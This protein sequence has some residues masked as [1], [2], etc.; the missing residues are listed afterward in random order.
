MALEPPLEPNV[1]QHIESFQAAMQ[2]ATPMTDAAWEMLRPRLLAQREAAEMVEHQRQEQLAALQAAMPSSASDEAF[3]KP[4]K[5]VYDK[6]YE[7]AQDPLRKR[8]AEYA[9]SYINTQWRGAKNLDKDNSPIF[10]VQVMLHV[11]GRYLED[12]EAG[13]LPPPPD[14]AG[15]KGPKPGTPAPEPFLTLDNM[16]WVYD[17]KI[18]GLTEQHRR[19]LFMC[20]LCAEEN[21]LKWFGF[22][23]LIQH[24]GAKHTTA[25]SKGNIV[26]HWQT[27]E[28]PEDPP[29]VTE[30]LQHNRPQGRVQE[31]K[32]DRKAS[33]EK[34]HKKARHTPQSSHS[35]SLAAAG[36]GKLL[37]ETPFFT[38]QGQ[39]APQSSFGY[40]GGPQNYPSYP[41][42]QGSPQA[43]QYGYPYPSGH[44]EPSVDM[45]E[46]AQLN[47]LS[48]DAREIWDGLDGVPQLLECVRVHTVLQHV[49]SRFGTKFHRKPSLDLITDAL[50][51]NPRVR[52][53]K[54]AHSLACKLCVAS[55]TDGSQLYASYY[56]R[57]NNIKLYN[58]SSLISHF[59]IVH[60][61]YENSAYS[62]LD[63]T[64]DM[65]ELPETQLISDLIRA[66]GMD[67]D[68]LIIV[69]S[70]F[71]QA[72]PTPLPKIGLVREPPPDSGPDTGLASRLLDR[73]N[74]KTKQQTKKKGLNG[75]L[76][77]STPGREV[78]QEPLPEPK[79][80]EYDPRRPMF[81]ENENKEPDPARFDTDLAR[82]DPASTGP[83]VTAP[84]SL[85]NLDPNMLALLNSLVPPKAQSNE[86]QVEARGDR[87][88]SVGR[89]EPT[90]VIPQ[91]VK[92]AATHVTPDIAAILNSLTGQMGQ[93]AAKTETTSTMSNRSNSPPR[94]LPAE[95]RNQP[96]MLSAAV[97]REERRSASHYADSPY[98][99]SSQPPPQHDRNDFQAAL[100]HNA[101]HYQQNRAQV[102]V[103][104]PYAPPYQPQPQLRYVY[105]DNYPYAEAPLRQAP[106]PQN[107]QHAPV[108]YLPRD[109]ERQRP[110]PYNYSHERPAPT[111]VYIDDEGRQYIH[112]QGRQ[113]YVQPIPRD[114][115][116]A[117]VQ[118]RP[119]PHEPQMQQQQYGEAHYTPGSAPA[120][121]A[122]YVMQ[123]VYEDRRQ[124]YSQQPG[125]PPPANQAPYPYD[126]FVR[127]SMPRG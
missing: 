56:A 65:I 55:Q 36:P 99:A 29:F 66:P 20:A 105:E 51:T 77:A 80:D 11:R 95:Q 122:P 22:E 54:N 85:D 79:E 113:I 43:G 24:Y 110:P 16:K 23:A 41:Y 53:L 125:P 96:P 2:I 50:A 37:S 33:N 76:G 15:K 39:Q 116:P 111:T 1:L 118:Y 10:A 48:S 90:P 67:D 114:G 70:A 94:H 86:P 52:P 127:S 12:R 72:F 7:K 124:V 13:N 68:K 4:A 74:K 81:V 91:T 121:Q 71:P 35:G 87:S 45:S 28:W 82:K 30:P 18:R 73:A 117:P 84:I 101:D 42:G 78:S 93:L 3:L 88:P 59:K 64:A 97:H 112:D 38:N 40:Y 25:F 107:G 102:Y 126:D 106:L 21:K 89:A 27:S 62:S 63:W 100:S 47:K 19:E 57:I 92:A 26:V 14:P 108:Q 31:M 8:L 119:H 123:P 75:S 103:E 6:D 9:D 17:N 32:P 60:Q 46:Q 83:S 5:E 49:V 109:P 34:G 69:A 58:I 115:A 120:G 44:T 98:D 104:Q 61:P